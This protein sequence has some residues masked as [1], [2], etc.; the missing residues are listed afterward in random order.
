MQIAK[1]KL[2][3]LETSSYGGKGWAWMITAL[4]QAE[5]ESKGPKHGTTITD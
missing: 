5:K 3:N 1:G 4:R 2:K